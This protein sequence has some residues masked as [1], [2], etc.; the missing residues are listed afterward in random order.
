M[1]SQERFE[2]LKAG[3]I[4]GLSLLLTSLSFVLINGSILAKYFVTLSSLRVDIDWHQ[5]ISGAIAA[6]CGLLFG[7]TY[8]YIIRDDN[9][10][11]LKVGAVFAFGLVR[12]LSQLDM[13]LN[14]LGSILPF[15]VLV[16]ESI[17]W[18]AIAALSVDLAIKLGWVKTFKG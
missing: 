14:T 6:I 5:L 2:S 16:V 18:F 1:R 7:L 17:V 12:G 3:I 8:R 15:I 4:A 9:N 10:P 13:G 11:Q